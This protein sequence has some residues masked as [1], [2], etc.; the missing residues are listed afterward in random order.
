MAHFAELNETNNVIRVCTLSSTVITDS[1]GNEQEQIGID[2]LTQLSGGVGWYKQTS[3]NGNFRKNYAGVGYTYDSQLDAFIPAKP[4]SSW[5]L[6]EATCQWTAPV[7]YPD[8]GKSYK[9]D[10]DT[11][12]WVEVE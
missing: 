10:E 1:D 4:Y 12:N 3:Y 6:V 7:T 8:D 11:T 2:L 9:W 5:T